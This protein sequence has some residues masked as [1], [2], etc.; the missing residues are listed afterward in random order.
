MPI[1]RV[2]RKVDQATLTEVAE[3]HLEPYKLVK[4]TFRGSGD[5][6]FS[7]G[8]DTMFLDDD[9]LEASVRVNQFKWDN[10]G[11]Q[12][13]SI[14]LFNAENND[15][16]ALVLQNRVAG[17]LISIYQT[18]RTTPGNNTPPELIVVGEC[19]SADINPDTGEITIGVSAVGETNKFIPNRYFTPAEGF[20]HIP[21]VGQQIVWGNEVFVFE[22][23]R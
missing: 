7:E 22:R 15:A 5:S 2:V 16:V 21:Q 12:R 4:I 3:T 1:Q 11:R 23:A 18:Y 9:Y 6:F 8:Q 17:N 19:G 10:E 20:N 14:T 13:G